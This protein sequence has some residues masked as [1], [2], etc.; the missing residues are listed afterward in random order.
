M[1]CLVIASARA[2]AARARDCSVAALAPAAA[3]TRCRRAAGAAA[4]QAAAAARGSPSAAPV[5]APPAISLRACSY[6]FCAGGFKA[7]GLE[8]RV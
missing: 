8:A 4:R 1:A 2:H 7:P 5:Q 6:S 3:P